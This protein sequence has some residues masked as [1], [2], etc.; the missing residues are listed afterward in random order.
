MVSVCYSY[1]KVVCGLYFVKIW[2]E[3]YGHENCVHRGACEIRT[4]RFLIFAILTVHVS[5]KADICSQ[6][7]WDGI[8]L[9]VSYFHACTS[10]MV[11]ELSGNEVGQPNSYGKLGLNSRVTHTVCEAEVVCGRRHW[12]R[13]GVNAHCLIVLLYE[14]PIKNLNTSL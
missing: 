6:R 14:Y 13:L 7:N 3:A 10:L 8:L 4:G 1:M 9:K 2:F 12:L 5:A 11:Y